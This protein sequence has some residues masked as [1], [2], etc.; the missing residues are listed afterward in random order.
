MN[1]LSL[2]RSATPKT[3][4]GGRY[5]LGERLGAGGFGQTFLAE[6]LHLPGHPRCVIKRLQPQATDAQSLQIARRLF[7]SEAN[8]LYQLGNHDQIPRLLAHFEE[9]NEFYLA[10]ELIVGQPL[11]E[12]LMTG[13]PWTENQVVALLQDILGV[14]DF[15]HNHKVIHRDI[16]PANLIRRRHD[17][18]IVLIDFGAVK[19]ASTQLID[20][21]SKPTQTISI[22]THG[23][24][25]NEQI[26][27]N[28][29][30]SSDLYAVGMIG[31]QALT[32]TAPKLLTEDPKTGEILWRHLV[33]HV[34]P[35]L[36]DVLDKMVRYDFRT[37]YPSATDVLEAIAQLPTPAPHTET[38]T[39][40]VSA[41]LPEKPHSTPPA[42]TVSPAS[43]L[44]QSTTVAWTP[45]TLTTASKPPSL[46]R[47]LTIPLRH[48]RVRGTT[49]PPVL[50]GLTRLRRTSSR[51]LSQF[52]P[53]S[54]KSLL[55]SLTGVVAVGAA[56]ALFKPGASVEVAPDPATRL[57]IASSG[58][59]LGVESSSQTTQLIT[60]A[61]QR[62]ES[63][64]FQE[65]VK[66]YDEAIALDETNSKAHWGRCYSLNAM[67]QFQPAIAA[68]DAAL[69]LQPDYPEALWSKGYA[70]EQQRQ[71]DKA[72]EL[73]NRAIELRPDF[74]EAWS[75]KGTTLFRMQ[76][77]EE[78]VNAFEQA[79]RLNPELAEAWN[80]RGAVLWSLRRFDEAIAS[81]DR[82]IQ[83][84]PDYQDAI[85]LRQQMR[86]RTGQ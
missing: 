1:F 39:L 11:T 14:L 56:I 37:R 29:R 53:V 45:P 63:K 81:V 33:P 34:S 66:L 28:P 72:L 18:K 55:L 15:V 49:P 6:D 67:T 64:D 84:Q 7:E 71:Y 80:N 85:N 47:M 10:Q 38:E 12:E 41:P 77:L 86:Q 65:A 25:P 57:P 59:S 83:I 43:T 9:E 68:C 60:Q 52:T 4:L 75:N 42:T 79:T 3:L 24:M 78:S 35:A 69:K 26:A 20:P 40:P 44:P 22:G 58:I 62:R 31:I 2:F 13:Q 48:T 16:K 17:R 8:V 61:D 32:G 30:F 70:L 19:L 21:H 82:A 51:G 74:A 23:Y 54:F 46:S 76:R 5:K 36:A 27:G 50:P 73:Y